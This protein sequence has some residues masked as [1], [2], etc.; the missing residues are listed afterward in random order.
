MQRDK[1]VL[2]CA[3]HNK[4]VTAE[5]QQDLDCDWSSQK[6]DQS[7]AEIPSS[8]LKHWYYNLSNASD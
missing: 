7:L 4:K 5:E 8:H 3:E 1:V 6:Y 2:V